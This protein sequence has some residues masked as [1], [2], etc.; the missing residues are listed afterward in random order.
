M[1]RGTNVTRGGCLGYQYVR[2]RNLIISVNQNVPSCVAAGTNNGC[3]PNATYANANQYSPAAMSAVHGL[4][5]SFVQR[6]AGWGHY[7]VSYSRSRSMNDVGE[8]FFSAPIDP[9]DLSKDWGRSDGDQRHRLVLNGSI[10]TPAAAGATMWQTLTHG[11]QASGMLQVYSSLPLNITSGVTTVQGT[12]GR[13]IVDGAFIARNAGQGSDFINLNA[14]V[15][16]SFR[17]GGT[18]RIEGA[19]EGFNLTNRTNI[20]G[21]N[22]TFGAG[23]YPTAPSATFNQTTAVAD[24][25]TFQFAVRLTF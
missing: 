24:P 25:R 11:F 2:G 14:R 17:L 23:A 21:R 18:T 22:A 9:F 19:I 8:A 13:P 20:I 1:P 15:S 12:P 4:H 16:R 3:R 7:R 10:Q 6:P 5:L